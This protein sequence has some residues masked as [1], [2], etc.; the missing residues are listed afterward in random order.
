MNKIVLGKSTLPNL[1]NIK[2][3]VGSMMN[4]NYKVP[5]DSQKMHK[6]TLFSQGTISHRSLF[7]LVGVR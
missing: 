6:S 1:K 2:S 5:V 4:T 7:S 3:K